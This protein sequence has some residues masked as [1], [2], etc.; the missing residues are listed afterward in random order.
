MKATLLVLVADGGRKAS[1]FL[2]VLADPGP[3]RQDILGLAVVGRSGGAVKDITRPL[4]HS[5]S[6]ITFDFCNKNREPI[7][8]VFFV[9]G[10]VVVVVMV[11]EEVLSRSVLK[12][13]KLCDFGSHVKVAKNNKYNGENM[14][15]KKQKNGFMAVS[16]LCAPTPL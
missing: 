9:D 14:P 13:R 5:I 3:K 4:P 11:Q 10:H 1:S 2:V 6:F 12:I 8:G 16:C 15:K 7:L